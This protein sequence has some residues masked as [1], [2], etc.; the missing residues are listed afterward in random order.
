MKAIRSGM[1]RDDA[2]RVVQG[3]AARAMENDTSLL[4]E[5]QSDERIELDAGALEAAFDLDTHLAHAD[6]ALTQL[7]GITAEWLRVAARVNPTTYVFDAMRSLLLDGWEF[8]PLLVGFLVS[9]GFAT[10]TGGLA[11]WQARRS[12]RLAE[13]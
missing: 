9:L 13:V 3:A 10:L 4:S 5:L 2:Y 12:T 8:R 11:L 1:S 6:H 7:E